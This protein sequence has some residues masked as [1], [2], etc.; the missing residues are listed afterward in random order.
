MRDCKP[1]SWVKM[2]L[3][4]RQPS[5]SRMSLL[6]KSSIMAL[7]STILPQLRTPPTKFFSVFQVATVFSRLKISLITWQ[8][9]ARE[10]ETPNFYRIYRTSTCRQLKQQSRETSNTLNSST[11]TGETKTLSLLPMQVICVS[12]LKLIHFFSSSK[13]SNSLKSHSKLPT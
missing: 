1:K 9:C 6:W 5:I 8:K 12:S 3:Q 2:L 11:R 7:C 13:S 4:A 10:M